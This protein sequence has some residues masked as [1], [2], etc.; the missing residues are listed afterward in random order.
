MAFTNKKVS[1]IFYIILCLIISFLIFSSQY[2]ILYPD[3]K[4]YYGWH[5]TLPEQMKYK[6]IVTW[7]DGI[8]KGKIIYPQVEKFKVLFFSNED[9]LNSSF[10]DEAQ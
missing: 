1:I 8:T 3:I 6:D 9:F 10:K 7:T 2:T 4:F 5:P